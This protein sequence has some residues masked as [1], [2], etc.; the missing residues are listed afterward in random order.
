M[1]Q[2]DESMRW[3]LRDLLEKHGLSTWV[4]VRRCIA[5]LRDY[6]AQSQKEVALLVVA[7]EA[8]TP[9]QLHEAALSVPVL[10][11]IQ[12]LAGDIANRHSIDPAAARWAVD[13]WAFALGLISEDQ[14]GPYAFQDLVPIPEIP[15]GPSFLPAAPSHPVLNAYRARLHAS[16]SRSPLLNA[17]VGLT[18]R[19]LD[20]KQIDNLKPGESRRLIDRLLGSASG[21]I[22]IRLPVSDVDEKIAS[23]ARQLARRLTARIG[24]DA[25]MMKRETGLH[26]LWLGYPLFEDRDPEDPERSVQCPIFLWP[27]VIEARADKEGAVRIAR[28]TKAGSAKF[29]RAMAGWVQRARGVRLTEPSEAM[30]AVTTKRTLESLVLEVLQPLAG[31]VSTNLSGQLVPVPSDVAADGAPRIVSAAILGVM[32]WEHQ[33]VLS[34][35]DQMAE[36]DRLPDLVSAYFGAPVSMPLVSPERPPEKDKYLVSTCD[37]SQEAAIWQARS[38]PGAVLY[39]P[40]GTGKSQTIANIIAD[41]LARGQRVLLVCQKRAAIEVVAERLASA[42]LRGLFVEIHD[43]ESDRASVLSELRRQADSLFGEA[44]LDQPARRD[45]IADEIERL[46]GDAD[47]YSRAVTEPHPAIGL[48]YREVLARHAEV[49]HQ[50]P[51]LR[52]RQVLSDILQG[53]TAIEVESARAQI[54]SIGDLWS[55]A[56]PSVNPWSRCLVKLAFD[57]YLIEDATQ[58][59]AAALAAEEAHQ[60][61]VAEHGFGLQL[62]ERPKEFAAESGDGPELAQIIGENPEVGAAT[63]RWL[64]GLRGR[65][66]RELRTVLGSVEAL[67]SESER[68]ADA[69]LPRELSLLFE[70]ADKKGEAPRLDVLEAFLVSADSHLRVLRWSYWRVRRELGPFQRVAGASSLRSVA[71]SARTYLKWRQNHADLRERAASVL[72]VDQRTVL[73][74]SDGQ[75]VQNLKT[76]AT[77]LSNVIWLVALVERHPTLGN[78]DAALGNADEDGAVR[79]LEKL[80]ISRR[81]ATAASEVLNALAPIEKWLDPSFITELSGSVRAGRSIRNTLEGLMNFCPR[82]ETLLAYRQRRATLNGWLARIVDLLEAEHASYYAEGNFLGERWWRIVWLSALAGWRRRIESEEPAL[83]FMTGSEYT[84]IV[85][86]I[87]ELIEIKRTMDAEFIQAFW[88]DRRRA[89]GRR[90]WQRALVA[91]GRYAKRLREAVELGEPMGLF[92]LRPCWMM[93]PN[94]A[95]Q[96][97]PLQEGLFNLVIFDE[98]SQCPVEQALPVI[99]RAQ[100]VVVA[101]DDKQLAP[102]SF[103]AAGFDGDFED[104]P[105]DDASGTTESTTEAEIVRAGREAAFAMSELLDAS[106]PILPHKELRVHYRSRHPDL[107][108]FSNC[109]FYGKRLDIPPLGRQALFCDEPPIIYVDV[110]DAIYEKQTNEREARRIVG[111]LKKVWQAKPCPTTGIVTFNSRQSQLIEDLLDQE[112]EN[113][114]SFASTLARERARVERKLDVGFFC[115]NLENVQGDERDVIIV[116]TTFGLTPDGH[117]KRAFGPLNYTRNNEGWRRLNVLVTRARL[118]LYIVSSIPVERVADLSEIE[119][120][121]DGD[122]SGRH[123]LRLYLEYARAVSKND[124]DKVDALLDLTAS[125]TGSQK[126]GQDPVMAAAGGYLVRDLT[127]AVR[128]RGF[129]VG[130]GIGMGGFAVDL[131]I[132]QSRKNEPYLGVELDCLAALSR[133]PA[134]YR[135][136]WRNEVLQERGLDLHRIWT[137]TWWNRREQAIAE[138]E[139]ALS[140]AKK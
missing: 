40:P 99:F 114:P 128:A 66:A 101:G 112:C 63:V 134:R 70:E 26:C 102:T 59:C 122:L 91:R 11:L 58:S 44:A 71:A 103:W 130:A 65:P 113:D 81:R 1:S 109:A 35:L 20:V 16:V 87:R 60:A 133:L 61:I 67:V 5:F 94:T 68:L 139:S 48:P 98:A 88:D 34:D 32:K 45:E 90:P 124:R 23:S 105:S 41:T 51:D 125:L 3:K 96:I 86:R 111:L 13:C 100:R 22:E 83:A 126:L 77:A 31:G 106:V 36:M 14:C 107:I 38:P 121:D 28:D 50:Y 80:D 54:E 79:W 17:T 104:E 76:E 7:L 117:F 25:K 27:I 72:P 82:L 132:R 93:N 56:V 62:P 2:F 119:G 140:Q 29:N 138:L 6:F 24:R 49:I 69:P 135:D 120:R 75:L 12:R 110:G 46:E 118:R 85:S 64:V 136:I 10:L 15:A 18:T 57:P 89:L 78:L 129:D 137:P 4:D 39:G 123:Y 55:R 33:A 37:W 74:W 116:G 84:S 127:E 115:K 95:C 47:R 21:K 53:L 97:L 131:V 108:S 43:S 19:L 92:D 73:S 42:N 52:P 8:G 9:R 30:F